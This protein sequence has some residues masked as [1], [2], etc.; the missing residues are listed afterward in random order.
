[1]SPRDRDPQPD[2]SGGL[3]PSKTL[4]RTRNAEG[5]EAASPAAPL[6]HLLPQGAARALRPRRSAPMAPAFSPQLRF[7]AERRVRFLPAPS[8]L[9][10]A[11][12]L[13]GRAPA[14]GE[15]WLPGGGRAWPSLWAEPA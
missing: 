7:S 12:S 5:G 10:P 14:A 4:R 15:D 6:T 9:P 2:P 3:S 8:D 1:M 13:W 11:L